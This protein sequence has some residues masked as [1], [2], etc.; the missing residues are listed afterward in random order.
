[1]EGVL[2]FVEVGFLGVVGD[3]SFAALEMSGVPDDA[4]E[5]VA[6]PEGSFAIE[7]FVDEV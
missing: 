1:M 7:V 3:V 2:V 4:V 6:L 5:V